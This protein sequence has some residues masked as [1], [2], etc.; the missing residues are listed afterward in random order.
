MNATN[1][2]VTSSSRIAEMPDSITKAQERL[3]KRI[4]EILK[5]SSE[6]CHEIE[7]LKEGY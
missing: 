2:K 5:R 1:E 3:N 6:K 4:A 7:C